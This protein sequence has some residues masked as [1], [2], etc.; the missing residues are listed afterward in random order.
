MLENN[1]YKI[2]W[3][4][5]IEDRRQDTVVEIKVMKETMTIDV[6]VL[7]VVRVKVKENEKIQ[8]CRRLKNNNWD[9]SRC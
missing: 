3:D 8:M 5:I 1:K 6:A 4:S 9:F 2:L 7:R